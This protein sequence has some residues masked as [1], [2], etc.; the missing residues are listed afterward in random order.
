MELL[1]FF[2]ALALFGIIAASWAHYD[3]YKQNKK[4]ATL[5]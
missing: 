4:E 1:Y 5:F 3:T 2:G